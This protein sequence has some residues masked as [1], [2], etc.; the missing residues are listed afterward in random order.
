MLYEVITHTRSLETLDR[1][2]T[3]A[4]PV[5]QHHLADTGLHAVRVDDGTMLGIDCR[6]RAAP[7]AFSRA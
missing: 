3:R 1:G 4:R 5:G 7:V 2:G 6:D